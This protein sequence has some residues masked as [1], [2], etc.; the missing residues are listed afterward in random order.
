MTA[1]DRTPAGLPASDV[2]ASVARSPTGDLGSISITRT[3]S[4]SAPSSSPPASRASASPYRDC[5]SRGLTSTPLRSARSPSDRL[6][7]WSR[8]PPHFAASASM[9]RRAA[10]RVGR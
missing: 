3:Y 8:Q 7:T 9:M 10:P 1:A 4:L 5:R 2:R 6:S